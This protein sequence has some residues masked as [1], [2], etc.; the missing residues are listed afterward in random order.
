MSWLRRTGTGR[1]NISW[2]GG[3]TTSGKYLKRTGNAR[4]NIAYTQISSNGTHKLLERTGT[5][6]NNIRW[7]NLTFSFGPSSMADIFTN[8]RFPNQGKFTQIWVKCYRGG[9]QTI[10]TTFSGNTSGYDKPG[11]SLYD[12]PDAIYGE[13]GDR[14]SISY[15]GVTAQSG[16]PSRPVDVPLT[17]VELNWIRA[18]KVK[19]QR[20]NG[21]AVDSETGNMTIAQVIDE[22][23]YHVAWGRSMILVLNTDYTS[24]IKL[25]RPYGCRVILS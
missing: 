21:S 24:T 6:R 4:N 5:G 22:I 17:S 16:Q 1:N 25:D 20:M 12:P 14:I 8:A 11:D 15:T 18:R 3:S 10:R 19:L 2:G 9:W 23:Q 7:N 13:G